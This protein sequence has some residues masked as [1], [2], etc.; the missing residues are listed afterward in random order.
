MKI[1]L[2]SFYFRLLFLCHTGQHV[3]GYFKNRNFFFPESKISTSTRI[4]ISIEFAL[5]HVSDTYPDSLYYPGLLC[6]YWQ[7]SMRRNARAQ[8]ICVL[9]FASTSKRENRGTRL[10]R[11]SIHG[12]EL[13]SILL[14]HRIK[15]ISGFNLTSTS[16][17]IHSVIKNFHSGEQIKKVADSYAG[18]TE[19]VWTD[20]VS[21]KKNLRIQ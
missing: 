1:M 7:Q 19:Y 2:H 13:G 21:E 8:K 15:K 17:Q 14:S 20:S 9:Q 4:R 6:E 10:P 11:S 5:Q 3:S 12:K 18:F 16:F